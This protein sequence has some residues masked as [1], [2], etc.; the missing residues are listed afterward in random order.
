MR[1]VKFIKRIS[2][3]IF[4]KAPV[5][6]YQGKCKRGTNKQEKGQF[7]YI[8]VLPGEPF[9]CP[10]PQLHTFNLILNI[11]WCL[12]WCLIRNFTIQI[13]KLLP[14]VE[15]LSS[16]FTAKVFSFVFLTFINKNHVKEVV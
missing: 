14:F 2:S 3:H 11:W 8:R 1:Q 5:K 15:Y 7:R 10:N 16:V 6:Q 13:I 4:S 12:K 9:L